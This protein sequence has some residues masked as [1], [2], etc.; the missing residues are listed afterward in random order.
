MSRT[1]TRSL[2]KNDEVRM[3]EILGELRE[4]F[5]EWSENYP[6]EHELIGFA[7][8]EGCGRSICCRDILK[9]A[10]PIALGKELVAKHDFEWVMVRASGGWHYA[11]KH[12]STGLFVD[13]E[14]IDDGK[15][16]GANPY[17]E[18][19]SGQH[20]HDS[21]EAIIEHLKGRFKHP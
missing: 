16:S 9:R 7:Y 19:P 8:Y 14:E 5:K 1:S 13:L 17:Q 6:S 2:S 15:W 20:T 18:V 10:A 12:S 11:V 4:H 3:A 21:Y